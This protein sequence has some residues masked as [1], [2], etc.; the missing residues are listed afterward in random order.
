MS[1]LD[2][3][4]GVSQAKL[5]VAGIVLAIAIGFGLYVWSL[6]D[7]IKDLEKEKTD[8]T[9]DKAQ[10]TQNVATVKSN[11]NI[12]LDSNATQVKTIVNLEKEREDSIK[13][14]EELARKDASNTEAINILKKKLV[15]LNA[16]AANNGPLA[17][18]LRETIRA[19]QNREE[20]Q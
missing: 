12:C 19:I 5:V 15:K 10:L 14:V 2:A 4:P 6:K 20:N 8:L 11:F 9:V 3:V 1:L 16:D 13:A 18:N 7:S 17:N